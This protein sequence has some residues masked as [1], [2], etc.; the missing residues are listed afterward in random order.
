MSVFSF[1]GDVPQSL[2]WPVVTALKSPRLS[3]AEATCSHTNTAV[4]DAV[5]GFVSVWKIAVQM[6]TA[7]CVNN[8]CDA[9][10]AGNDGDGCTTHFR[11]WLSC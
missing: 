5:A 3:E 8:A 9:G 1:S 2:C 4:S 11:V 7:G 10:D 6:R